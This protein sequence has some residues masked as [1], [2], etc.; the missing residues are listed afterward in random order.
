VV[1]FQ[2]YVYGGQM[3]DIRMTEMFSTFPNGLG[4]QSRSMIASRRQWLS[5]KSSFRMLR[6]CSFCTF[7]FLNV[8]GLI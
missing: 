6:Y 7:D 2:S 4:M 3:S 5:C 1:S 8:D